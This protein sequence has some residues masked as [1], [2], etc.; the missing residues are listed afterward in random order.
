MNTLSSIVTSHDNKVA[1]EAVPLK[2]MT[3]GMCTQ[4]TNAFSSMHVDLTLV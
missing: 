1:M 2:N 4:K 3:E